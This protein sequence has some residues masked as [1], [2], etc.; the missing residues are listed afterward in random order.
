[1]HGGF[2]DVRRW[3]YWGTL[4]QAWS[5]R[6]NRIGLLRIGEIDRTDGKHFG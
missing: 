4:G 3:Q 1:L 5:L 6:M 2:L